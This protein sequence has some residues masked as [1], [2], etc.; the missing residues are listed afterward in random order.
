MTGLTAVYLKKGANSYLVNN[1]NQRIVYKPNGFQQAFLEFDI[2]KPADTFRGVITG[3]DAVSVYVG[4]P[5]AGGIKMLDGYVTDFDD[6]FDKQ[7]RLIEKI[8]VT[9][10]ISYLAGK[11]IFE[12]RYWFLS[13]ATSKQTF[14]DA[15]GE[16]PA[17]GAPNVDAGLTIQVKQE[18]LGTYVKDGFNAAAQFGG[19]DYFG[20]ENQA[21]QAFLHGGRDLIDPGSG[22]RYK[23]VDTVNS[24]TNQIKIDSNFPYNFAKNSMQKFRTVIAS[25]AVSYTYPD[26]INKW[27][28]EKNDNR[29]L[30][31]RDFSNH[32]QMTGRSVYDKNLIPTPPIPLTFESVDVGGDAVPVAVLNVA[33]AAQVIDMI[34][35]NI[36]LTNFTFPSLGIT[37]TNWQEISFFFRSLLTPTPT[38]VYIQ[39]LDISTG[40]TFTRY[41]KQGATSL[42]LAGGMTFLRFLLPTAVANN[43]WTKVGTFNTI[44]QILIGFN[45]NSGYTANTSVKIAQFYL[46]KRVRKTSSTSGGTPA[47]TK[48]IVNRSITDE[49]VLLNLANAEWARVNTDAYRVA[50]TI[51]GNTN[52][53]KP[54]YAIDV[55]FT[56]TM[57]S[58]RS[59]TQ[60]RI[61][62]ITHT[63]NQSRHKTTVSLKPAF[64]RL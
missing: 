39:M 28:T 36:D 58:G 51:P 17:H 21:L 19:A 5:S 49:T 9:D 47:T 64:Q 32:F 56:A 22:I 63:L 16:M 60:M 30:Y 59:G 29:G 2:S 13:G 18:F 24:G 46:F 37:L 14:L 8:E 25:N 38:D 12:K 4:D 10:W 44:D 62:E 41:L 45:P 31:G 52:F 6:N 1:S 48:I 26:D 3:E 35:G 20:D 34:V 55:D 15:D 33:S 50:F 27:I 11:T 23:I 53:K 7:R 54:G 61:D 42:L 43:G 57:G 40:G